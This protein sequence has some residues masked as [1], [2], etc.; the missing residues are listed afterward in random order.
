MGKGLVAMIVIILLLG[1]VYVFYEYEKR[2]ALQNCE[3]S[4][5]DVRVASIGLISAKLE[6]VLRIYNPND[7]TATLDR[8]DYEL[9]GNGEFLGYGAFD[10]SVDIPPHS[11]RLVS[12]EFTLDYGGALKTIWSALKNGDVEWRIK[13]VAHID[14]PIGTLNIPFEKKAS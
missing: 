8:I 13:G 5:A 11:F 9:Y 12:S 1:G 7:V 14:T 2:A 6:V 3:I 4:L 10:R